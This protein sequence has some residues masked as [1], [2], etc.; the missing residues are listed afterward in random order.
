M[1][2]SAILSEEGLTASAVKTGSLLTDLNSEDLRA[3]LA[4]QRAHLALQAAKDAVRAAEDA[5][6][7]DHQR[8]VQQLATSCAIYLTAE[9]PFRWRGKLSPAT[10]RKFEEIVLFTEGEPSISIRIETPTGI[11]MIRAG[12]QKKSID[13]PSVGE[14][15][16][17]VLL[18]TNTGF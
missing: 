1:K 10:P 15:A 8:S 6:F 13:Y 17:H 14:L 4:V 11:A 9:T 2:L 16:E 18:M 5:K 12:T 7:A 3:T